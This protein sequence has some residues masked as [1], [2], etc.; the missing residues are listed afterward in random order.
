MIDGVFAELRVV[1]DGG[2]N[3]S[4]ISRTTFQLR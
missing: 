4:I 1:R 2:A 3:G